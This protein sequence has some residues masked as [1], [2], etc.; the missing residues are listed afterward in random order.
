MVWKHETFSNSVTLV[1]MFVKTGSV[2]KVL[3]LYFCSH[4]VEQEEVKMLPF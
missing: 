4:S 2:S 1:V 3:E